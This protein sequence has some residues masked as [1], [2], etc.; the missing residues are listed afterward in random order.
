MSELISEDGRIL[1]LKYGAT[2]P[3]S[4]LR[5]AVSPPI[6]ATLG[7][8]IELWGVA[9]LPP[10]SQIESLSVKG[11]FEV[12]LFWCNV[13]RFALIKW[14]LQFY[15]IGSDGELKTNF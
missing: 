2:V 10:S 5:K 13:F 7:G 14:L 6:N 4:V 9:I 8:L 15:E 3:L 1:N 11:P 12:F